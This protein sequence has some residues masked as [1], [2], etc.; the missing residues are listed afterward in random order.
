MPTTKRRVSVNLFDDEYTE[1]LAMANK[2]QVSLGWIGRQAI[3]EFLDHHKDEQLQLPLKLTQRPRI[4][5]V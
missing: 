1:L 2:H 4:A 5:H 3:L